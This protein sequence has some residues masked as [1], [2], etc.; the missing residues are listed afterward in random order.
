MT[1][2]P[3]RMV[4]VHAEIPMK[5]QIE[6][7]RRALRFKTTQEAAQW[8][9]VYDGFRVKRRVTSFQN[10]E[11]IVIQDWSDYDFEE[12]YRERIHALARRGP[13]G[14]GVLRLLLPLRD[15]PGAA[16][17]RARHRDR[18]NLPQYPP[19]EHR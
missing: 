17:S 14:G 10:G 2:I 16:A 1:V 15:E 12:A 3:V 8:G 7:I 5:K 6:E 18:R 13:P 4:T 11:E 9:P 19:G